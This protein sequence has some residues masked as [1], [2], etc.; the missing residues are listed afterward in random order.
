M[1]NLTSAFLNLIV[2]GLLYGGL[3][4][5]TALANHRSGDFAL[6]ENMAAADLDGDGNTDIMR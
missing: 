2:G 4:T 1:K 6:P 3:A 5:T